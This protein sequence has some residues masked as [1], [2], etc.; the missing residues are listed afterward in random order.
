[1]SG[2]KFTGRQ[3]SFNYTRGKKKD[4]ATSFTSRRCG[5]GV[6]ESATPSLT[7]AK[8]PALPKITK[9]VKK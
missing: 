7:A 2:I 8:I 4:Q 3:V 9:H 1:M 6:K 5:T